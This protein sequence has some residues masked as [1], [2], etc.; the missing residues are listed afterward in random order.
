MLSFFYQSAGD[1]SFP[2]ELERSQKNFAAYAE[3]FGSDKVLAVA[4]RLMDAPKGVMRDGS[5]NPTTLANPG[6]L[7]CGTFYLIRQCFDELTGSNAAFAAAV[8]AGAVTNDERQYW[9]ET[10]R[11]SNPRDYA[12]YLAWLEIQEMQQYDPSSTPQVRRARS[13]KQVAEWVAKWG[14]GNVLKAAQAVQAA[15]KAPQG[16]LTYETAKSVGCNLCGAPGSL[17]QPTLCAVWLMSSKP[18]TR[19]EQVPAPVVIP[20]GRPSPQGIPPG[21][22]SPVGL[23]EPVPNRPVP[24]ASA[25]AEA[26]KQGVSLLNA[27]RLAEAQKQFEGAIA[28]DPNNAEAHYQL[29]VVLVSLGNL[30]RARAEIDTYLKLAPNG[31]NTAQARA[32]AARLAK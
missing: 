12:L 30:I 5:S 21:R 24:T 25:S 22:P 9:T 6:A 18:A 14:E 10:T 29:G 1:R 4:K 26:Y 15:P 20:P 32:L 23:G 27:G 16:G 8:K 13:E 28:A 2:E 11:S 19:K 3:Q 31:P 17:C 7:G